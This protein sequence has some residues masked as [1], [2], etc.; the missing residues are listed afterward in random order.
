MASPTLN[1]I[2][3]RIT[4]SCEQLAT[5]MPSIVQTW[6]VPFA[7]LGIA[8]V[9]GTWYKLVSEYVPDPYLVGSRTSGWKATK[10]KSKSGI[11]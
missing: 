3:A 1:T 11:G 9:A 8:A 6:P 5:D 10:L 7:L 2:H 4:R